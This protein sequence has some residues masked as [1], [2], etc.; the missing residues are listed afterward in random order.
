MFKAL[1]AMI[2]NAFN[3]G[4]NLFQATENLSKGIVLI[5]ELAPEEAEHYT[6]QR[7]A[8]NAATRA[9]TLDSE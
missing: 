2:T 7:R 9:L 3:S 5:S 4:A 6:Q 1:H 8:A